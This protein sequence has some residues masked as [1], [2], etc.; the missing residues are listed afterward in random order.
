MQWCCVS[1]GQPPSFG[2]KIEHRQPC[3][4]VQ[5]WKYNFDFLMQKFSRREAQVRAQFINVASVAELAKICGVNTS[6]SQQLAALIYTSQW[7]MQHRC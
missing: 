6:S 2:R 5:S 1:H 4:S 3:G 7:Q